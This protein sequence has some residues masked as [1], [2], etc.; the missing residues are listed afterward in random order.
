[1]SRKMR[2][3][4]E[5]QAGQVLL[6]AGFSYEPHSVPYIIHHKYTPDFVCG[7]LLVEAKGWFRPG[8]RQKYKAIRDSLEAP[9]ELVFLLMRPNKKVSKGAQLTMGGWCTKEDIKW[10][11]L[12]TLEELAEYGQGKR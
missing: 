11:D 1:V 9:S 12:T 8:D 3:K 2:S 10:F 6:P 4:F 7:D 5:E